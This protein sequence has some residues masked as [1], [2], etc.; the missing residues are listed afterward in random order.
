MTTFIDTPHWPALTVVLA[1][2]LFGDALLSL[3]P[4]AF[5]RDCLDGVRFPRDW[6]WTLIVI[7]LVAVAGLLAGL[8]Y[9]GVGVAANAGVVAYF[10]CAAIAHVRAGFLGSTFWVNCLGMLAFSTLVLIVSYV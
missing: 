10:V 8:W 3:R 6:W 2:V 1:A 5:I 9:P 7:K 4:P